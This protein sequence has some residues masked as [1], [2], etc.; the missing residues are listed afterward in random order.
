MM[1]DTNKAFMEAVMKA[2]KF[3]KL[4]KLSR[5]RFVSNSSKE[6]MHLMNP[7]ADELMFY[8]REQKGETIYVYQG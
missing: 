1:N 4:V 8:L 3:G 5:E 6:G 7:T 2:K